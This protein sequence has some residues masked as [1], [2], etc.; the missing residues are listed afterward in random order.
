MPLYT[1]E[2]LDT[3]RQRV[4]LFEVLSSHLQLLPSG[5]SYKALCPF[6]EEKSPS[7]ILKRGD[8]HYHCFGCGAHG[9][10]IGFLMTFLKISFTE[11]TEMLAERFQVTLE[12]SDLP[13]ESEQRLK[14]TELK[15]VLEKACEIYHFLLLNSKEGHV[16]LH[17]LYERGIDLKFIRSFRIGYA[18]M[19]GDFL[20]KIL[21]A[22]KFSGE[23]IEGAGLISKKGRDFFTDRI[24]FPIC[25]VFGNVIGFSARK[26]KEET[27]GGKYINTAETPLFKKSY[28]LFGLSYSRQRIAKERQA[29]IVEGQIDAL[30]LIYLGFNYTV[31]GQGTAFGE[32]HAKELM[33]LGVNQIFLALDADEAGQQA[34]VKIGNLFQKR[35]VGVRVVKLPL[36]KDPDSFLREEG[37]AAFQKLLDE[38]QDYV[39]FLVEHYSQTLDLKIPAQK[40]QLIQTIASLIR[41]WDE[42]VMVHESLKKLAQ[43]TLVPET[44]IGV[45]PE[46]ASPLQ[47]Q[48]TEKAGRSEIDADRILESDLLRW[49]LLCGREEKKL[50][51]IAKLNLTLDH[52]QNPL[53]KQLFAF[54]LECDA[55]NEPCDLISFGNVLQKEEDQSLLYELVERKVNLK[56]AEEGLIEVVQRI[57]VREWMQ[58]REEIKATMNSGNCTEEQLSELVKAFDALKKNQPQVKLPK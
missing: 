5:A 38:G 17:Y 54:Y 52:F 22:F 58:K 9:D 43:Q 30:R 25:D 7:F 39:P 23:I 18:P 10:A 34:A 4:D 48:K 14:K 42:P 45:N 20:Q 29:L 1:K 44:V 19:P 13:G 24:T 8:T 31:A 50:V 21:T 37:A 28:V 51:E 40:N 15:E 53:C 57:I 41:G 11:A 33:H 36:G 12:R 32:E 3:L 55:K 46:M 47:I 6:H 49:L 27:F 56:R 2:S 35:G 16:A 26:F